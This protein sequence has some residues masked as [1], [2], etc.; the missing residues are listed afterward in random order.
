MIRP[1]SEQ[2][3]GLVVA[4]PLHVLVSSGH[5]LTIHFHDLSGK[6]YILDCCEISM[7][8][9]LEYTGSLKL[10]RFLW[11]REFGRWRTGGP[12]PIVIFEFLS[13]VGEALEGL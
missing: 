4:L 9:Y 1:C 13:R 6:E 7:V 5:L 8:E 3:F 11:K 2:Q 10:K 12:I